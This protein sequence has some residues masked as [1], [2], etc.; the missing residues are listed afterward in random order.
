M[1]VEAP[2]LHGMDGE[3]ASIVTL[4]YH[5]LEEVP[6]TVG[7]QVEDTPR[8]GVLV[9]DVARVQM[10][11]DGMCD[12]GVRDAVLPCGVM[13]IHDMRL[14]YYENVSALARHPAGICPHAAWR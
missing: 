3:L 9:L 4:E 2:H 10:V 7:P 5:D 13:D 12:V 6:G 1:L 11:R 14:S 8:R